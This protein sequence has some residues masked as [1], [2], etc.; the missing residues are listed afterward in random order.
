MLV[1]AK[2]WAFD[3]SAR[4]IARKLRLYFD[5]DIKYVRENPILDPSRYDLL[6][7]FFWGETY[8]QKFGFDPERIIKEVSSHR[9][10]D[11]PLYGPCTPAVFA[12]KYLNDCGTVICTSLRLLNLIK[13]YHPNA[14]H[15]PN[16]ISP[17]T[18]KNVRTRSGSLTIGWAG[19]IKDGVKGYKDILEPACQDRYRLVTADGTL[20]HAGMNSFYNQLDVLAICSQHEGEPLTLLESMASGCFPVCTDVGIVPEL[21]EHGVNGFIVSE[22]TSDAFAQAFA[23]CE[24]NLDTIRKAG[25]ENARIIRRE[26]NWDVCAQSFKRVFLDVYNDVSQPKFRNDDVSGDTSLEEFKKFCE[27]FHKYGL[28]QVHGIT[29]RGN[30][31]TL[32][33]YADTPVE[34]DGYDTVANLD[35]QVIRKLSDCTVFEERSDLIDYLNRIPDE[36]ALHGLFHVDY[37]K[38]TYDEQKDEIMRGLDILRKLFPRKKIIYFIPPFNRTNEFTYKVCGELKL[39]VL[40]TEGVHLESEIDR[41]VLR[42]NT[43]YRYH[44]HRFYLVS[45]FSYYDLSIEKLDAALGKAKFCWQKYSGQHY[46][47]SHGVFSRLASYV[48][49]LVIEG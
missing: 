20:A 22:R 48:G 13:A 3:I 10:E 18:F 33:K 16:G 15:T 2:D 44:H 32:F 7:V 26:R 39:K 12:D 23:W 9:W 36:I 25:E 47:D 24:A 27:V 4:Q 49:R 17:F 5:I 34:Y 35:N 31:N 14:C 8:Y 30:T 21:I 41:L 45:V 46:P 37:S 42:K 1:D 43:W 11:N 29:L 19:N 28:T 40:T 38:M 6:Y